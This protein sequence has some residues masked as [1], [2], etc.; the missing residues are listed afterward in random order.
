MNAMSKTAAETQT[1]LTRASS[2]L[3]NI[4]QDEQEQQ[5]QSTLGKIADGLD[6]AVDG[7]ELASAVCRAGTDAIKPA[8]RTGGAQSPEH[9]LTGGGDGAANVFQTVA[10]C[11]PDLE[12]LSVAA[13]AAD[14]GSGV[15]DVIGGL[16]EGLGSL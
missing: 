8:Y 15:L 2:S 10:D 4:P 9:F 12:P 14:V 16:F 5:Q 11:A 6:A 3:E 7:T 1:P 13:D